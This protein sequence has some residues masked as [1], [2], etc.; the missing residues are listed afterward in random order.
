M[1]KNIGK[2]LVLFAYAINQIDLWNIIIM[3]ICLAEVVDIYEFQNQII[4]QKLKIFKIYYPLII[5]SFERVWK[6]IYPSSSKWQISPVLSQ[7]FLSI[8]FAV[9][10]GSL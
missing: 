2:L 9:F 1:V 8:D 6:Y 10:S 3:S 7:L 5:I 4:T